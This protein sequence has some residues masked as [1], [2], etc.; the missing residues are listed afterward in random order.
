MLVP[1]PRIDV[2]K[3]GVKRLEQVGPYAVIA[4]R[5]LYNDGKSTRFAVINTR[6]KFVDSV[7]SDYLKA[8][9][10]THRMM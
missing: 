4:N 9:S 2:N 10:Y 5:K 6:N 3:P 1:N 7:H 8:L